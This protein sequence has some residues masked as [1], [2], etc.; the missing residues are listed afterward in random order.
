MR[1][2]FVG[3]GGSGKTTL[4]ALFAEYSKRD[5]KPVL[6]FDADLNI[7][8]PD[9]LGLG[10]QIAKEQHLSHPVVTSAIKNY[11]KGS[12]EI[13]NLSAFRKT[14]PPT[15]KSNLIQIH[16]IETS[17]LQ[18]T[19]AQKD[20]LYLCVIGTYNEEQ[21]GASCYHNNLAIFENILSHLI[22]DDGYVIAD[23]VAGVDAFANTLHAQFD[24]VCIIVEP[25]MRSVEVFNHYY[26]LA[27]EASTVEQIAVV[28][29]KVRNDADKEFIQKHIPQHMLIDCMADSAYLRH[30]EQHGGALDIQL[31]ER[32][33]TDILEKVKQRLHSQPKDSHARLLKLWKLHTTYVAQDS[34]KDRFG[35]LTNQI[36]ESFSYGK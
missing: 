18:N 31:L 27:K 36:D 17:V 12:N 7:H 10:G 30:V 25:T 8:L 21:I 15:T 1:I 22:D 13:S 14:T 29:N 34:I 35:D 9:L 6:V 28:G 24:L 33:N 11:L 19:Y 3:K 16:E 5:K 32:E 4:A 2:A 26:S 20:N 23:M